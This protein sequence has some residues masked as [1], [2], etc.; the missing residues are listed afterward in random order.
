MRL[1]DVIITGVFVVGISDERRRWSLCVKPNHLVP[2]AYVSKAL[3]LG[4]YR[5]CRSFEIITR[6]NRGAVESVTID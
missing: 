6:F 1:S 5:V 2:S 3:G 4:L